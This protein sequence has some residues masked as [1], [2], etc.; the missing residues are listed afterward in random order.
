MANG[1]QRNMTARGAA[2]L[3]FLCG[4]IGLVAGLTFHTWKLGPTG[5]FAGGGLLALLAVFALLD[6]ALA[7]KR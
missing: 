4:V 3:A 6:G 1:Q 7:A 2:A 5:W